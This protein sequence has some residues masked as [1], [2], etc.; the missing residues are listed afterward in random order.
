MPLQRIGK[1]LD[2]TAGGRFSRGRRHG[3][4]AI[5]ER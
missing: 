5:H 2:R 3:G 1:A 4:T